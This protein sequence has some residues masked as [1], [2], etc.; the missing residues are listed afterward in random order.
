MTQ[1]NFSILQGRSL[2]KRMILTTVAVHL[3]SQ[4]TFSSSQ[5]QTSPI[6]EDCEFFM[7]YGLHAG[8]FYFKLLATIGAHANEAGLFYMNGLKESR[9]RY[10]TEPHWGQR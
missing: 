3:E 5:K 4:V 7:L 6:P 1:N 10:E 2:L 9:D 8:G